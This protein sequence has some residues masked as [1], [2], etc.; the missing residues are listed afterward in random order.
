MNK[1]NV[2]NPLKNVLVTSNQIQRQYMSGGVS[3]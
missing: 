3:R 2:L 1:K